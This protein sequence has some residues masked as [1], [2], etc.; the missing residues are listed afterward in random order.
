MIDAWAG[1]RSYVAADTVS[2]V[3]MAS[4]IAKGNLGE[5]VNGY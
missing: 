3:D 2:Y 4:A 5:A 1:R